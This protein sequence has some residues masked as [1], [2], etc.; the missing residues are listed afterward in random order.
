MLRLRPSAGV[1]ALQQLL[2]EKF[3]TSAALDRVSLWGTGSGFFLI[4]FPALLPVFR[5]SR[6]IRTFAS[7]H[8]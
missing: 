4:D 1:V 5:E 7:G 8:L 6:Q 2:K 3:R